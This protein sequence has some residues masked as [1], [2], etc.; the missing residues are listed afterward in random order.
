MHNIFNLH[1]FI[2]GLG[3]L[4]AETAKNLSLIGVNK[5]TFLDNDLFCNRDLGNN[6]F[7]N[8]ELVGAVTK[9]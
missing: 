6:C 2:Q 1:V 3:G 8:P 7:A 9:A 5:F 4:G